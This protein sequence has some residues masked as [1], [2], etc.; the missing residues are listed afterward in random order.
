MKA[1][2]DGRVQHIHG[3]RN[4]LVNKALRIRRRVA[5]FKLEK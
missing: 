4:Y 5:G 1:L 2:K 3:R